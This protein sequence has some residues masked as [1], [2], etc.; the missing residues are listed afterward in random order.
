MS[1]IKVNPERVSGMCV[2]HQMNARVHFQTPAQRQNSINAS[3]DRP[4]FIP[5]QELIFLPA[6]QG[7]VGGMGYFYLFLFFT[8]RRRLFSERLSRESSHNR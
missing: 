1:L 3:E 5:K 8:E 7:A 4:Q 6:L 2:Q